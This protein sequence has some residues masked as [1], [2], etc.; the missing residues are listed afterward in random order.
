MAWNETTRKQY[1]RPLERFET[2][3]TGAK[4]ASI[5]QLLPPQSRLGR[6][7]RTD[8]RE[9]LAAKF[10]KLPEWEEGKT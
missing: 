7:R 10:K 9:G 4:W 3:V 8:L 6:Q 1:R 5:E 2:D